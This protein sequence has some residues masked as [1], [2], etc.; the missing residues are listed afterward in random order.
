M[1]AIPQREM[2]HL[3][4]KNSGYLFGLLDIKWILEL[5]L[6]FPPDKPLTWCWWLPSLFFQSTPPSRALAHVS[7]CLVDI[8]LIATRH[9]KLNL[10]KAGLII[11]LSQTCCCFCTF[12]FAE[13]LTISSDVQ[14]RHL[15]I[16]LKLS[17]P[18]HILLII[19]FFRV[20]HSVSGPI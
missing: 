5:S 18:T 7:N 1:N 11:L 12:D 13:D 16:I 4:T 6:E 2:Y 15:G 17:F 8:S 20:Y 9:L 14:T 3:H 19:T 10:S